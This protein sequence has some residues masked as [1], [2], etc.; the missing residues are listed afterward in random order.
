MDNEGAGRHL[1]QLL[2]YAILI[3][4]PV[5][6]VGQDANSWR[7]PSPHRVE[8]VTV[9]DGV[10]LEVLDWGGTGRPIVLLAGYLTAHAFDDFAPKLSQIGH[11]YGITRRGF[12]ASSRPE[13]GYTSRC[14]AEDVLRVLDALKLSKPVLMGHSFGGQDETILAQEHPER[15]AGLVYLNSAEDPT[16][17]DYGV[18]PPDSKKLPAA[19]R[20]R[21]KPDFSSFQAYRASQVQMQGV[22]FPESELRQLYTANPDGT[23]G[24]YLGSGKVREAMFKGLEKPDFSR[25]KAPVL[26]FCAA[27]V[28]LSDQIRKYKPQIDEE[29]TAIEQQYRFDMAVRD[30]HIHDLKAGVPSARVVELANANFYIFLSNEADLMRELPAFVKV[31]R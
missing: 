3:L 22:A 6:S 20:E 26:A 31:L 18:V 30:R 17:T 29:R 14:L 4:F 23:M 11:V 15:I 21:P 5:L 1:G 16:V 13:S 8:F 10:R 2:K 24:A 25:V 27:P 28:S 9:D 19:A 7:D 12:G